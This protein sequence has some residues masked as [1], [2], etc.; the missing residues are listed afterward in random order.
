MAMNLNLDVIMKRP[1]EQK[2]L[3]LAGIL[4][5]IFLLYLWLGYLPKR[6]DLAAQEGELK[7]QE[8]KLNQLKGIASDLP[9]FK[10]EVQ[11][12]EDRLKEALIKLPNKSEVPGFLLDISNQGKEVG[13]EFNLFKPKSEV[14]KGLYAEVPV[15][16][17][18][19]GSYHEIGTFFDRV[20]KLPR[21]VNIRDIKLG[22]AKDSGGRWI[23]DSSFE[24]VIF[25]FLEEG[26]IKGEEKSGTKTK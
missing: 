21:I 25:R 1:V 11:K 17:K 14:R 18:I 5:F 2:L 22:G 15:D 3:I 16:V 8:T 12:L 6:K 26:E 9:K 23:L 20:S 24:A 4:V 7:K 19:N 13:L 10:E